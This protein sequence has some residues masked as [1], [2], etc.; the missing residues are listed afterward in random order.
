MP[1]T[2]TRHKFDPR[3]LIGQTLALSPAALMSWIQ[4]DWDGTPYE[5][6]TPHSNLTYT[7]PRKG[8][9][10]V[11][12]YGA[13][14]FGPFSWNL[15]YDQLEHAISQPLNDLSVEHLVIRAEGPGGMVAGLLNANA[16]LRKLTARRKIPITVHTSGQCCSAWAFLASTLAC[17]GGEWVAEPSAS[18]GNMGLYTMLAFHYRKLQQ[19]G[20]DI[21][22]VSAGAHKIDLFGELPPSDDALRREQSQIDEI[23]EILCQDAGIGLAARRG[24][25]PEEG[26]RLIRAQES[27]TYIGNQEA[28]DAG[29]IDRVALLETVLDEAKAS[30]GIA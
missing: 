19:D 27:R 1:A 21:R 25:S 18:V 12:F 14:G 7:M 30:G 16:R 10:M 2:P 20:I 9:A 17:N 29:V 13:I 8:V 6:T 22:Y 4:T 15:T 28:I 11:S 24:I 3:A 5:S 26:Y 23:Y